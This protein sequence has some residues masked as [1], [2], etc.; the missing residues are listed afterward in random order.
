MWFRIANGLMAVLFA[1]CAA[2]QFN[3]PDPIRWVAVYGAA[4]L[5]T[6][7]ALLRPGHYPWFLPALLGTLA[8]IWCTT[9]LPRVA[10][11]V[12]PAELFGSR[13]MMSPLI[14]EGREA[15]GLLIVAVWMA[16]LAVAR[17]LWHG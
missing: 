17:I 11:K 1:Y 5:L 2:V 13:E 12:R 10:G 4:C 7:L 15:G 16:A 14:E 6:V 3:D 9:I 8:A